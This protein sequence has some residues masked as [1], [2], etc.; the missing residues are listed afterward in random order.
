MGKR[1]VSLLEPAAT[2]LAEISWFIENKGL[3]D[4]AKKFVNDALIF[5]ENLSDERVEHKASTYNKWKDL[6]YRCVP[7]KKKYTVAYLSLQKEIVFCDFV[8]S[9]LL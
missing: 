3:P 2:A 5:F 8:A 9:R 7:Y 1:K 6:G 4:I